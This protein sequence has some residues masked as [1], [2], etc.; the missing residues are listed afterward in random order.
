MNI[1]R[2]NNEN[3]LLMD[4]YFP[5]LIEGKSAYQIAVE[6]GFVGTE[7]DWLESL[8]GMPGSPATIKVGKV[9]TGEPGS[10]ASVLNVG[11]GSNAIFD[12]VIPRGDKGESS[13]MSP[14][15]LP[16]DSKDIAYED[17]TVKDELDS[18]NDKID[19]LLYEPIQIISFV[20]N[21]GIVELGSIVNTVIFNWNFNKKPTTQILN[22][23]LISPELRTKALINLNISSSKSFELEAEDERGVVVTKTS[24]VTFYNG[25]YFYA[26]AKPPS[27][28]NLFIINMTRSL[29]GNRAKTFTMNAGADQY[30]YYA[31]P[32]RYGT[33]VFKVGGFEGGFSKVDTLDFTN[34]SGY[35][36]S[37]DIW[38]SDNSGLGHTTVVVS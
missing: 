23:E 1:K 9:T 14:S 21:T 28:N 11:T 13:G 20:N 30:I 29:Q 17:T 34:R 37:Y 32:V 6:D 26:A 19:D 5:Q 12:F 15:P 36:E 7:E 33:P 10:D 4:L 24:S 25:V 3:S 2:V 18:L 8:K 16:I 35:T 22:D 31:L 38:C 27:Y